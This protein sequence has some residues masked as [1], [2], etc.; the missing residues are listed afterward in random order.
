M[1]RAIRMDLYKM[2]KMKS[3]YVILI[4]MAAVTLWSTGMI[5]AEMKD[6]DEQQSQSIEQEEEV[7]NVGINVGVSSQSDGK[8]TL[9][10]FAFG[11]I[12]GK[13]IALFLVIFSV[14]FASSDNTTGYIKNIG[15]QV[16][17]RSM[18]IIS[19]AAGLLV[20]TILL[21]GIYLLVQLVS[22]GIIFGYMKL[23]NVSDLL[24]YIGLQIWLHFAFAL[25]CMA[26]AYIVKNNVFTMIVVIS[27]CANLM[28]IF[29]N[30][31]DKI[32][33]KA[34]IEGFHM[35]KYTITGRIAMLSSQAS[36]NEA[37]G[38][39]VAGT[40]VIVAMLI[41]GCA[42]FEKRDIV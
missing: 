26:I 25:I 23:G 11:N 39:L 19:K 27:M 35:I 8:F 3:F 17:R 40:V 6:V 14:L 13:V 15:G 34:G 20:Y 24:S 2:F 32:I 5:K 21:F 18:L 28:I 4:V 30:G 41:V 31:I 22:N 1:S 10:D 7:V 36:G 33:E 9:M 37:A 16:S 38:A 42:V 29:Y 12:Q